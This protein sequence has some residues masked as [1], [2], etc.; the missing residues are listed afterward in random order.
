MSETM[1]RKGD[2]VR[3][4]ARRHRYKGG[5]LAIVI[6]TKYFERVDDFHLQLL[7]LNG[8]RCGKKAWDYPDLFKKVAG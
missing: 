2:L 8:G 3:P 5:T 4:L 1:F 7:W 6:T